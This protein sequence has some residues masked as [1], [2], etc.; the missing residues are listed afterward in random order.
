MSGL[1]QS[2]AGRLGAFLARRRAR[3]A[4]ARQFAAFCAMPGHAGRG[5]PAQWAGAGVRS[6][7][8]EQGFDRHYVLH[9][10]WAARQVAR[11][12]PARHVDIASSLYFVAQVS[13]FVPVDFYDYRPP[14]LALPGLG[15]A[16]A[17]L[18][19][20][21]FPDA[22]VPS[23]SCLHVIEHVGL[24][25]YGDALDPDGDRRAAAELARVLAPGG[26]LLVAVP[27]GRARV[28]FN[29]HRV[30][31]CAQV[32]ALF[33]GLALEQFALVPDDPKDGGLLPGAPFAQADAQQYGCGCFCFVKPAAPGSPGGEGGS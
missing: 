7:E 30:Y 16:R 13:A 29:L 14:D 6:G 4:V 10:A 2:A 18:A 3:A 24:G 8:T 22:S 9:T 26:T 1:F 25:R 11:L 27:V 15:C 20:L 12:A 17:D 21:P 32:L 19:A 28:E 31:A 5:L 23:L 33:P